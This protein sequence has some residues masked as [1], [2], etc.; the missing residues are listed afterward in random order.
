MDGGSTFTKPG[1][2][3][4]LMQSVRD[5]RARARQWHEFEDLAA[6]GVLDDVLSEAGLSRADLPAVMRAHPRSGW[7][8][9]EMKRWLGVDVGPAPPR[10]DLREAQLRCVRCASSRQCEDWLALPAGERP[11]P[12]FCP[13][14]DAFRRIRAWQASQPR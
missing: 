13:N 2:L 1:F 14:I 4:R 6:C 7:R 10:A 11:V 3:S 12:T 5:R 9:A 8:H